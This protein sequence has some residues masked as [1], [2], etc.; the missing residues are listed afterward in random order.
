MSF[1]TWLDAETNGTDPSLGKKLLQV[2]CLITD[3]KFNIVSDGFERKVFYTEDEVKN[4]KE[5][6]ND[7]VLEMHN[8][9]DLWNKLTTEGQLLSVIDKELFEEISKF[10]PE[11]GKTRLGGNSITLDRNFVRAFLPKSF[12]QLSHQS[13]DMTSVSGFLRLCD[14]KFGS[15]EKKLAHDALEDIQESIDEAKFYY[16]KISR[17]RELGLRPTA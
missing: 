4:L 11:P 3:E 10:S 9:T 5:N 14:P 15:Y 1:I 2:A 6:T 8:K 13:Y 17:L 16:K 12:E 7:F